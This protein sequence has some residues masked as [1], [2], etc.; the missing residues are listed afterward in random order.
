MVDRQI[1]EFEHA[2]V[3]LG[4]EHCARLRQDG[5]RRQHFDE[6]TLENFAH[7]DRIERSVEGQDAAVGRGRV[8]AVGAL[9]GGQRIGRDRYAAGVRVLDDHAGRRRE[10][11]HAL[12]GG[13]GVGNIV[14]GQFL[15][16]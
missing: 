9:I 7:G 5:G 16:L 12:D 4:G 6:L 11:A 3:G 15:A 1:T 8:G 2:H 10:L 14:E 13:V